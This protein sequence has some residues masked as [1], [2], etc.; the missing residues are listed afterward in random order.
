[1]SSDAAG[2]RFYAGPVRWWVAPTER[3]LEHEVD[4]DSFTV[5]EWAQLRERWIV[6]AR[7]AGMQR[8]SLASAAHKWFE[9]L[10]EVDRLAIVGV[11]LDSAEAAADLLGF[12]VEPAAR[13]GIELVVGAEHA[14]EP[15]DREAFV[16]RDFGYAYSL[17]RL[18]WC[19]GGG[20]PAVSSRR[21]LAQMDFAPDA[22]Q[23]QA[24]GARAG[25]VQII[26]PA[27]SGKTAVLIERVREL[28][29]RGAPPRS[30]LALTFNVA[31]REEL[32]ARLAPADAA[33]VRAQTFHAL[34]FRI[35]AE[36]RAIPKNK[37]PW[38][39]TLSQW[40]MLAARAKGEIGEDGFW[41]DP[42]EAQSALSQVK[43]GDLMRASEYTEKT[44]DGDGRERTLAALYT[45][46]EA[47]QRQNGDRLDFDDM[48]LRALLLLRGDEAVRKRWQQEFQYVLVDEYQD[49]EPAQ[50]LL[51]RLIAAPQDQ[52]FC[53]GDEDQ[54]LYA[55]RRASVERII[56]LDELYPGLQ[57][58]A[59]TMNYRCPPEVVEASRALIEHNDVRFPKQIEPAAQYRSGDAI[60][61]RG[62]SRLDSGVAAAQAMKG[63]RRG[64]ISALARTSDALRPVALACADFGVAIDGPAKLFKPTG[65]RRA[66]ED[67]LRLAAAPREAS[68]ELVQRVFQTPGRG[69]SADARPRVVEG[70]LEGLSFEIVFAAID[71]PRRGQGKLWAPAELF[72]GLSGQEDAAAAVALLRGA[73][74]FD[75][76]F[77][78]ADNMDGLDQFEGEALEQAER[79]AAGMSPQ[80]FLGELEAQASKL[81]EIRDAEHGIELSTIHGAKGRQWPRVI[82]VA[83]DEGILPH[84]RSLDVTSEERK[85]GE[86]LEAER[87]LGYV[88]F[89]RAQQTLE[90]HHDKDH[91]SRFLT[92]AGLIAR[93][94]RPPRKPPPA[95]GLSRKSPP[96]PGLPPSLGGSPIRDLVRRLKG[97]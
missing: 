72:T 71:A 57:R 24:I 19:L 36:A 80:A 87:R 13:L 52:L 97:S 22:T 4:L 73:G 26:A 59:L 53:V 91:P 2:S 68:E 76:W 47:L 51:V 85:R 35:L 45:G 10:D 84:K 55:F 28:L 88:A 9:W 30:I 90:I 20:Q 3:D 44:K 58:V 89:T 92:E 95:P 93:Q 75:E 81:S 64:E 31:A 6:P 79:D 60:V 34:G 65:A 66:I 56:L 1:M 69:L 46:Y 78:S 86:G 32:E 39:P 67:H 42:P 5:V 11:S 27:G 94:T 61:L 15:V 23:K 54:T 25:V 70:L 38:N 7:A 16:E 83:C 50:E 33:G 41:F 12:V 77:Q 43:L 40:R 14:I 29:R 8:K 48:I 63:R 96:V 82:V 17:E 37:K 74:G 49:I 21:S 18:L 62:L